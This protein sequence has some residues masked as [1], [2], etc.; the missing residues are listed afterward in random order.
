MIDT[1]R[2]DNIVGMLELAN[3]IAANQRIEIIWFSVG[4]LQVLPEI[5]S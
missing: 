3:P 1:F 4:L 2:S 5:I